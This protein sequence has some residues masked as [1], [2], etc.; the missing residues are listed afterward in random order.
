MKLRILAVATLALA[1]PLLA[2]G[3][4]GS[5]DT[6]SGERPTAD[7]ISKSFQKQLPPTTPNVE[8]VADCL[9]KELEASE[10][11]NGVLRSLVAGEEETKVDKGNEE[12]Y[13]KEITSATTACMSEA[14]GS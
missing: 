13:T 3:C 7:E 4:G 14:L 9:G 2:T 8:A 6:N 12:K 10:L 5:D 11:P 1:L